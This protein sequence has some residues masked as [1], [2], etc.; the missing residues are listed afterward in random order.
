MCFYHF[1]FYFW[2][3]C[4]FLQQNFN[5]SET[6]IGD[7]KFSVELYDCMSHCTK[8]RFKNHGVSRPRETNYVSINLH[9]Q[10]EYLALF[11]YL[12]NVHLKYQKKKIKNVKHLLT[13]NAASINWESISDIIADLQHLCGNRKMWK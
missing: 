12:S 1:Y 11:W 6:V 10:E 4:R 9:Q 5:Q 13:N 7:R 3:S 2:W 8:R